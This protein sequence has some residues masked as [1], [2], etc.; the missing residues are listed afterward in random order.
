MGTTRV[1]RYNGACAIRPTGSCVGRRAARGGDHK[2]CQVYNGAFAVRPT[3]G[4]LSGSGV[5]QRAV[6]VGRHVGTTRVA[7]Y[8][9]ACAIRSTGGNLS[10]SG[11]WWKS[12]EGGGATWGPRGWPGTMEHEQ[13]DLLAGICQDPVLAEEP[14][15]VGRHVGTTRIARYNS[16]CAIRPTCGNLSGAVVGRGATSMRNKTYPWE[17]V[18][19][20]CW[21]KSCEG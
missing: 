19:I 16:A 3:G 10:G 18:R 17:S 8:N 9:K 4:N 21:P 13:Q 15:G 5:G 20:W 12:R 11:V 1:T 7:R 2:G 14:R 6:R